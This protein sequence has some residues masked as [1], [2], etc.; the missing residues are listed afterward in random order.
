[1]GASEMS[2]KFDLAAVAR[3]LAETAKDAMRSEGESEPD[4]VSW[5]LAQRVL[6]QAKGL[7]SGDPIVQGIKLE[8]KRWVSLRSAMEAV[9]VKLE[10]QAHSDVV[11]SVNRANAAKVRR[12]RGG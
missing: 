5:S 8:T 4:E 11:A 7:T 12:M 3:N 6:D 1:M 2:I 10:S 9:A